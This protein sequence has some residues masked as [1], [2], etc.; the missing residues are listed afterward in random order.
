MAVAYDS[1]GPAGGAGASVATPT[2][3]TWTHTT[4][5]APTTI[6]AACAPDNLSPASPAACTCDGTP[7]TPLAPP[8]PCGTGGTTGFLQ[9]FS[10]AGVAA[11]AH[12]ITVTYSAA[13]TDCT[14][15]SVAFT[16]AS[17]L[18]AVF[19]SSAT[20]TVIDTAGTAGAILA[21][22][23]AA[24]NTITQA[25][26][27]ATGLFLDNYKGSGG[28]AAGNIAGATA[29][30]TGAPVTITWTS[31]GGTGEVAT[32]GAEVMGSWSAGATG[33]GTGGMSAG[34]QSGPDPYLIGGLAQASGDTL[35]IPV[36][37]AVPKGDMVVVGASNTNAGANEVMAVADSKGNTYTRKVQATGG[38]SSNSFGS[39]VFTSV[40]TTALTTSDTISVSFATVSSTPGQAIAAGITAGGNIDQAV[41]AYGTGTPSVTTGTLSTEP[42]TVVSFF[43]GLSADGAWSWP[44]QWNVLGSEHVSPDPYISAAWQAV[45]ST[46][47]VSAAPVELGWPLDRADPDGLP[48]LHHVRHRCPPGRGDG[49]GTRHD[50]HVWCSRRCRDRDGGR[51]AGRRR[52]SP[53]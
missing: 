40:T 43:T 52:R 41:A 2:T 3:L 36:G 31:G 21:G 39:A 1:T 50:R 37:T 22:F 46:S 19:A 5:G 38:T 7:M 48:V 25:G 30:C 13:A 4:I 27:P 53:R 15:G 51:D 6:L 49:H 26:A 20:K 9:V 24:G 35:V 16:D 33:T 12:T 45:M 23:F 8:V 14:G 47:A 28:A 34:G 10:I 17:S 44:S 42:E 29:P 32:L 18:G 11:G